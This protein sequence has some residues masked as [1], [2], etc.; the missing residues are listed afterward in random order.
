MPIQER[1][2]ARMVQ[3]DPI[4]YIAMGDQDVVVFKRRELIEQLRAGA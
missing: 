3:A 2:R 1:L 4:S